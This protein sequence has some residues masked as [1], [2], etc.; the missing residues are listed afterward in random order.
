MLIFQVKIKQGVLLKWKKKTTFFIKDDFMFF[1]LARHHVAEIQSSKRIKYKRWTNNNTFHCSWSEQ[2][3]FIFLLLGL[4]FINDF[5]RIFSSIFLILTDFHYQTVDD[6]VEQYLPFVCNLVL[7]LKIHSFWHSTPP[8]STSG[9]TSLPIKKKKSLLDANSLS[10]HAIVQTPMRNLVSRPQAFHC[11]AGSLPWLCFEGEKL[12]W[13]CPT[14]PQNEDLLSS[15][16]VWS[17]D[18]ERTP[19][20]LCSAYHNGGWE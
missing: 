18:R 6:F 19:E 14:F 9:T 11:K 13:F 15:C 7:W 5:I 10:H 1:L 12:V 17:W 4:T 2:N 16:I 20:L 3:L 8:R